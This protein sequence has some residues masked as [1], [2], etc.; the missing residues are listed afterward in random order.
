MRI[1]LL[2]EIEIVLALVVALTM[3]AGIT[4]ADSK[5][6]KREI[7]TEEAATQPTNGSLFTDEGRIVDLYGDFKPRSIGDVIFIDIVESSAASVSSSAK[8]DREGSALSGAVIGAAPL[9]PNIAGGA[10]AIFGALGTRKFDGKGSTERK[11][12]LRARIAARVIEVLPNGDLRIEAEKQL[13]INKEEERLT[14]S[15]LVRRRDVS[16][17][18]AVLSTSVADLIVQL[19]GKGVAS[20]N[21]APG[22]L[23][24]LLEKIA[25]F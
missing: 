22:W 17:D 12:A 7:K 14:L 10:A 2:R 8:N 15:G 6:K 9:P 1:G 24:R 23:T 20:A 4:L 21:N 25:P 19:N 18:N 16:L 13:K 3:T 11:S 5:K